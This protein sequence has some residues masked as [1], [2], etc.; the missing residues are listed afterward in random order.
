MA[1]DK[2]FADALP[3]DIRRVA[4]P[5]DDPFDKDFECSQAF[6]S[7]SLTNTV[8]MF[9]L[10]VEHGG[11]PHRVGT[12]QPGK[13]VALAGWPSAAFSDNAK[14]EIHNRSLGIPRKIIRYAS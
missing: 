10:G 13:S 4:Y 8:A 11:Y 7:P 12:H 14:A 6:A 2:R 3:P 1:P 5:R 9:T